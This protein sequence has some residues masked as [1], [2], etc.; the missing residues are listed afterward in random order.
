MFE[1]VISLGFRCKLSIM[2]ERE[3]FRSSSGPFDW[4][5][6]ESFENVLKLI[7]NHFDN[8]ITFE[9]LYQSKKYPDVYLDKFNQIYF[10]HDFNNKSVFSIFETV[11][12]KYSRRIEH[13]YSVINKPT[14]FIR[15]IKTPEE[16]FFIINQRDYITKTIS[17]YNENNKIIFLTKFDY[18][19]TKCDKDFIFCKDGKYPTS[20]IEY[21]ESEF[22]SNLRRKNISF[23]KKNSFKKAIYRKT[24]RFKRKVWATF[25]HYI[26]S[27]TF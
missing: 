27:K 8:F 16:L 1:N 20:L 17:A 19:L 23:Y 22:D 11:R 9:N 7:N 3:G 24:M 14:L 13:F 12:K 25:P 15:E 18:E 21:L 2:L 6:T 26:H 4:V 5:V 10:Y